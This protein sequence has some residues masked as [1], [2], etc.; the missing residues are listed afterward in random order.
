MNERM[1]KRGTDGQ[2][3]MDCEKCKADLTGKQ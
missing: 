1:T 3:M 2:A